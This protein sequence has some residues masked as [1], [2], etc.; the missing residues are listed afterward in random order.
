MLF[1]SDVFVTTD[2][3]GIPI[4]KWESSDFI[5]NRLPNVEMPIPPFHHPIAYSFRMT[6]GIKVPEGYSVLL[7]PAMN[8]YDLPYTVPFGIV[9]ADTKFA[10][11]DIRF[12]LKRDFEGVIKKGTPL[13]Q[14]LPFKRDN[15]EM[16][17]RP[18]ITFEEM[19]THELRRT[20]LSNWYGRHAQKKK[21][22]N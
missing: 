4:F 20:Y 17:I 6:H 14:I 10:P 2:N 5:I 13:F 15:W 3:K 9:D 1:R 7:S 18:D 11:I 8:R 22:F 21:E 19:W 16:E 12:F